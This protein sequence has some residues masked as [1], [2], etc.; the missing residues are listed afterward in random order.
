MFP[1]Y[2]LKIFVL[3]SLLIFHTL[4]LPQ[5]LADDERKN[6]LIIQLEK[7]L[8]ENDNKNLNKLFS[9][10]NNEK[11]KLLYSNFIGRF[12]DP[13]WIVKQLSPISNNSSIVD[14]TVQGKRFIGE[15]SYK[16]KANQKLKLNIVN[17]QILSQEILSEYSILQ[18]TEKPLS[19]NLMIPDKVLTGSKYDFDIVL[20]DPLED[21]MLAGGIT[22]IT[23]DQINKVEFPNIELNP[24]GGGGLFKIIQAPMEPGYQAWAVLLAHPD[25]LIS[26]TKRVQVVA[27]K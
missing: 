6:D 11:F 8:N 18:N 15:H 13:K 26:I 1:R 17:N 27:D 3:S 4:P 12:T 2:F 21:S 16:L 22:Q 10:E 25:A 23:P 19:I 5:A 20:N 9:R 14:I 24:M 7:A